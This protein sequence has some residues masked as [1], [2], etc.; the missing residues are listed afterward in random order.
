MADLT[1]EYYWHCYSAEHAIYMI[2]GSKDEQHKVEYDHHGIDRR[3]QG[4]N[5]DCKGFKFRGDCKHIKEAKKKHCGWLQ[6]TD[7]GDAID[8]P[9]D[10]DHP[11]GKACPK[12]GGEV[13]SRGWGV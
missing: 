13:G 12:C 11:N 8:C 2:E 5:C 3:G 9:V 1:I 10:D 4:W 7:N 6:F